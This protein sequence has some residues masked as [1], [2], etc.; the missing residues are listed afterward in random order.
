MF[1]THILS[2]YNFNNGIDQNFSPYL[3]KFNSLVDIHRYDRKLLYKVIKIILGII[4]KSC[5]HAEQNF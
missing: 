1:Q 2:T 4:E 5:L 3:L